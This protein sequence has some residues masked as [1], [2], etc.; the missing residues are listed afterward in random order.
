M[1]W[2]LLTQLNQLN[3][4]DEQSKTA[5]VLI[6]KHSTRCSISHAALDRLERN[7]KTEFGDKLKIYYLDLLQHRD[8]SNAI[9]ERYNIEHQSPQ[10]LIIKDGKCIFSQ[11]H[12]G[13]RLGD[14][15]AA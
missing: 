13:I 10:A 14:L 12:S 8:I 6:F 1:N 7:W 2:Q 9:A 15:L 3:E 11:T 5:S 4:I